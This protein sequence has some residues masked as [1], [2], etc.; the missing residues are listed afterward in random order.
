MSESLSQKLDEALRK[1]STPQVT[2]QSRFSRSLL[3]ALI[4]FAAVIVVAFGLF[5]LNKYLESSIEKLQSDTAAITAEIDA[6][7]SNP[8]VAGALIYER[9]KARIDKLIDDN[10]PVVI[11]NLLSELESKFGVQ[12]KGF[13]YNDGRVTTTI[14]ANGDGALE[15]DAL[16]KVIAFI[17]GFRDAVSSSTGVLSASG[18]TLTTPAATSIL[19]LQ[20]ISSVSGNA[21]DR[22][23]A[24]EFLTR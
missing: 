4:V 12:T 2:Y 24:V 15:G 3:I 7:K 6:L 16:N 22:S 11:M 14:T 9:D 18:A 23:F 17:A 19:K 20:P 21:K 8:Q 1:E 10:N 5:G 13:S